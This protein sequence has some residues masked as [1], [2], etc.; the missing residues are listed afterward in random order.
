MSHRSRS[1]QLLGPWALAACGMEGVSV[2]GPETTVGFVQQRLE[3]RGRRRGSV[4]R[5]RADHGPQRAAPAG[6]RHGLRRP[7]RLCHQRGP[8]TSRSPR[9]RRPFPRAH[10]AAR[11]PSSRSP[12]SETTSP[13][14]PTRPSSCPHRRVRGHPREHHRD[15]AQPDRC[16]ERRR[17]LRTAHEPHGRMSRRRATT[18]TSSSSSPPERPSPLTSTSSAV[19]G[20][21]GTATSHCGLPGG[22]ASRDPVQRGHPLG[23]HAHR[24]RGRPR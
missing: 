18:W 11:R 8:T 24:H 7:V 12:P 13:R 14:E 22:R 6:L 4:H 2:S 17:A 20:G 10:S 1:W 9:S 5:R 15:P 16:R 3:P 21:A 23:G 19:D